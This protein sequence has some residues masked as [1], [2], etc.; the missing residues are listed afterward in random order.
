MLLGHEWQWRLAKDN[1]LGAGSLEQ[2]ILQFFQSCADHR[3]TV[4][5]HQPAAVHMQKHSRDVQKHNGDNVVNIGKW[6][7]LMLK[8]GKLPLMPLKWE[9]GYL[10][11][12]S[13]Q[14]E[15][16]P[17]AMLTNKKTLQ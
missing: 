3:D 13:L 8:T 17:S 15:A 6:P 9:K 2:N 14:A 11:G 10:A 1:N 7:I 4:D 5:L 12:I 16:G